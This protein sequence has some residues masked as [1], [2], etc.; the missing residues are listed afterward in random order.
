MYQ[1]SQLFLQ[2][3]LEGVLNDL[4]DLYDDTIPLVHLDNVGPNLATLVTS[5][6][7]V[8]WVLSPLELVRTRLVVQTASPTHRKYTGF[9]NCLRTSVSEEGW[10]GLYL[11]PIHLV[12]TV[13]HH[14][15]LPFLAN[16]RAL[17]IDRVFGISAADSPFLHALV[18]LGLSTAELLITLP[19]ETIRKRLQ[20]QMRSHGSIKTAVPLPGCVALRK[21]PY[22]GWF[23]CLFRII[24]EEGGSRRKRRRRSNIRPGSSGGPASA[25]SR[26]RSLKRRDSTASVN[27]LRFHSQ[28]KISWWNSWGLRGLYKGLGVHL[29][30]N[31]VLFLVNA[32]N[33]IQDDEDW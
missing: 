33:G 20:V 2:P 30:A 27:D 1:M 12:P 19:L 18:E 24:T 28:Q 13:L 17:V 22:S 8:G 5:H 7:I 15:I 16:T 9:M 23:D 25:G 26:R 14:T 29:T 32:V 11:S 10:R 4:F 3:T 31:S 21:R 6:V